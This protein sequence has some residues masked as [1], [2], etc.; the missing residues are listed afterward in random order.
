MSHNKIDRLIYTFSKL[1]GIGNRNAKRIVLHIINN[2]DRLMAPM[3]EA[4]FDASEAI[5]KCRICNNID[6]SEVCSICIGEK[7]DKKT[8]CVVESI[9]DLWALENANFYQGLYHVLG[10]TLS[11]SENKGPTDL[12]IETLSDR[13]EKNEIK[14]LIIATNATMEGQTTAFFITEKFREKNIKITRFAHGIP[15]GGELDYLDEVTISTAF[16]SRQRF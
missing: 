8:I 4:L 12:G 5:Q 1:P 3:A 2:K 13:I 7:R 16:G 10:G 6:E 15:I 14:E 9:I 11:S